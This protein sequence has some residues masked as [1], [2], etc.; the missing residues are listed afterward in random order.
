MC[1]SEFL[2]FHRGTPRNLPLQVEERVKEALIN[3][4]QHILYSK[5]IKVVQFGPIEKFTLIFF[6]FETLKND[7]T[8]LNDIVCRNICILQWKQSTSC[9]S[10]WRMTLRLSKRFR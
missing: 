8:T 3:A 5:I 9:L 6:N 7:E 1:T 10:C 4:C 2:E